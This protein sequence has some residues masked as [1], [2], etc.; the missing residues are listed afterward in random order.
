M[1]L[2]WTEGRKGKPNLFAAN[3]GGL[4]NS[5]TSSLRASTPSRVRALQA[6]ACAAL[7]CGPRSGSEAISS[8]LTQLLCSLTT[9]LR[10]R[11]RDNP[12]AV[13]QST[14]GK[15]KTNLPEIAKAASEMMANRSYRRLPN[16]LV[17]QAHHEAAYVIEVKTRGFHQDQDPTSGP[18]KGRIYASNRLLPTVCRQP[19]AEAGSIYATNRG[20]E[21]RGRQTKRASE[22]R[23]QA[24]N[25]ELC[26]YSVCALLC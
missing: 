17:A 10:T 19:C 26:E 16:L 2:A 9:R 4:A 1:N 3:S 22:T 6:P 12:K 7:D 20:R 11:N 25:F 21:T 23:A 18:S 8:C 13:E 15:F 14:R 24:A 5:V